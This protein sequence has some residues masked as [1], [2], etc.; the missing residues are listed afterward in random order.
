MLRFLWVAR[1][2]GLAMA[3]YSPGLPEAPQTIKSRVFP[4]QNDMVFGM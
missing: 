1:V 3:S 2:L 4:Q